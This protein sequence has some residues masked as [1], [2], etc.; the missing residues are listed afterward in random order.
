MTTTA[1]I[2]V[3]TTDKDLGTES[4]IQKITRDNY[5]Q[6]GESIEEYSRVL[7]L[8][9]N[10]P[11]RDESFKSPVKKYK[12]QKFSEV[13]PTK[14]P[15]NHKPEFEPYSTT[16][17]K[18][19]H[20][21]QNFEQVQSNDKNYRQTKT[22]R[23][24]QVAK[25]QYEEYF[26][27]QTEKQFYFNPTTAAKSRLE[28]GRFQKP[29]TFD[30][31]ISSNNY[32]TQSTIKPFDNSDYYDDMIIGKLSSQ[33]KVIIH[34]DGKIECLD[35]GGSFP[36]PFS[37]KQFIQCAHTNSRKLVGYVFNCPKNLSYDPVGRICNWNFACKM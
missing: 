22:K 3:S 29:S 26:E 32:F 12:L 15:S 20:Q 36:H 16:T 5:N 10:A 31:I 13:S 23:P 7:P 18:S 2:K 28:S 35:G 34:S 9:S 27:Q 11:L 33:V 19:A 30:K 8:I 24:V 1:K 17:Q 21:K 37:C 6:L 4:T 25:T 14:L